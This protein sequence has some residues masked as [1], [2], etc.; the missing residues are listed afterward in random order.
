MSKKKKNFLY[1]TCTKE[2]HILV[3]IQPRG[4]LR[5]YL[6]TIRFTTYLIRVWT[7]VV[8]KNYSIWIAQKKN[9]RQETYVRA[10]KKFEFESVFHYAVRLKEKNLRQNLNEKKAKLQIQT[11]YFELRILVNGIGMAM[12]FFVLAGAGWLSAY[13]LWYV[14]THSLHAILSLDCVIA[15]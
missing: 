4:L 1:F 7:G 10:W 12:R 9:A 5:T 14:L 6:A 2:K 13:V 15:Y 11:L 3:Y 8:W